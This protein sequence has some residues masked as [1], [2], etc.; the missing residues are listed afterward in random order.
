M[1]EE[2]R[3]G[4]R[5]TGLPERLR[6]GRGYSRAIAWMAWPR[7]PQRPLGTVEYREGRGEWL[8]RKMDDQT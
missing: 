5:L 6:A 1:F 7:F 2:V 4:L 8:A 3:N